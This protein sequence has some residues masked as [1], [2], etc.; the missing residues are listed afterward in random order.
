MMEAIAAFILVLLA[1][2]TAVLCYVLLYD[3]RW[4]IDARRIGG[5]IA[6]NLLNEYGEDSA[7]LSEDGTKRFSRTRY[8]ELCGALGLPETAV[9][10]V[11]SETWRLVNA[12]SIEPAGITLYE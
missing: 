6:A 12:A 10:A 3:R 8:L 5:A 9:D 2:D 4:R 11:V 1:V 7:A